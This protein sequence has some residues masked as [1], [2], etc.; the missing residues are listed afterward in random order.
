MK[1]RCE[2]FIHE[3]DTGWYHQTPVVT[4]MDDGTKLT[5]MD[6]ITACDD[7]EPHA[8][9][10]GAAYAERVLRPIVLTPA[11]EQ[12]IRDLLDKEGNS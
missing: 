3:G 4:E 5:F 11:D 6:R 12:V 7:G 9:D 2:R 8:P 1:C 10:L